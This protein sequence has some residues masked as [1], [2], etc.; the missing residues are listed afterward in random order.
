MIRS[1]IIVSVIS[2]IYI[3]VNCQSRT[4]E[5]PDNIKNALESIIE[6]SKD[7]INI[8]QLSQELFELIETPIILDNCTLEELQS[9]PV[10]NPF[11]AKTLY[12]YILEHGRVYSLFELVH[13]YGFNKKTVQ[14]LSTF[15]R[16]SSTRN[17]LNT[18]N[19]QIKQNL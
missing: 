9:I 15:V 5:L 17:T 8:E 2:F 3:Q 12:L 10:L 11:Q 19:H 13:L 6:S 18:A 14:L 7:E 4:D 1:F 16:V